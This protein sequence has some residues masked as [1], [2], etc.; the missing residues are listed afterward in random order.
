MDF[1]RC[2]EVPMKKFQENAAIMSTAE[3]KKTIRSYN[4]IA[5]TLVSYEGMW[6]QAW[7]ASI[8]SAKTG[9]QAP[10]IVRHPDDGRLHV[11]FD[12]NILQLIRETKLLQ[13]MGVKVP[14]GAELVL[15]QEEKIKNSKGMLQNVLVALEA[16][17]E[18]ILPHFRELCRPFTEHLAQKIEP[19]LTVLTWSSINISVYIHA[20]HSSVNHLVDTIDR[21][22]DILDNRV[23]KNLKAI[24]NTTL[25]DLKAETAYTLDDFVT[26]QERVIKAKMG[27]MNQRNLEAEA[28]VNDALEAVYSLSVEHCKDV[29]LLES[30]ASRVKDMYQRFTYLSVL[31]CIRTSFNKLKQ[32]IRLSA[33]G[34]I[35][36]IA[37]PFFIVDVELN[38]PEVTLNP[39]LE[40]IQ[41]SINTAAVAI[42]RAS[43]KINKWG[44]V[45]DTSD[46]SESLFEL[47]GCDIEIVKY[48]LLLTGCIGTPPFFFFWNS[49]LCVFG[50]R[51]EGFV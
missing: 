20:I 47:I 10:L 11:N 18:K 50:L 29:D 24:R 37:H 25:V 1:G 8:D 51:R 3:S 46:G 42:L 16:A 31:Q 6:E 17:Q 41:L 13:R 4:R 39:S 5:R 33:G 32:R 26:S 2:I 38:V 14:V 9:L 43:K 49:F 30:E 35:F 34:S 15:Q 27:F 22:R 7:A 23:D 36:S 19:G 40:D 45:F 48:V 12:H 21:V 28:A 44:R